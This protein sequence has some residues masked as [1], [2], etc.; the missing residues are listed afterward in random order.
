[1]VVFEHTVGVGSWLAECCDLPQRLDCLVW[2]VWH[3][4]HHTGDY[5]ML[6]IPMQV[7]P[8]LYAACMCIQA[9]AMQGLLAF[10]ANATREVSGVLQCRNAAAHGSCCA[11]AKPHSKVLAEQTMLVSI[12][13]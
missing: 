13:T 6:Y 10:L 7:L 2:V 5:V 9:T 11:A 12:H 8:C 4:V 3:V 1:M